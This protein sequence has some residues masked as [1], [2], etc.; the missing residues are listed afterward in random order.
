MKKCD[1]VWCLKKEATLSFTGV[2]SFDLIP[3]SLDIYIS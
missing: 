1:N 3:Y 2:H